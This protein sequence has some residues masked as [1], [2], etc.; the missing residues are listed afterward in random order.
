MLSFSISYWD[1]LKFPYFADTTER[2]GEDFMDNSNVKFIF[3]PMISLCKLGHLK[4]D[5]VLQSSFK[6][7]L[8]CIILDSWK[9][10]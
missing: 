5:N 2:E 8:F 10:N 1:L 9:T 6:P 4:K 3:Q 7:Y